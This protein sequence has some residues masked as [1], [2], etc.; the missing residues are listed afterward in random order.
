M[1]DA[2]GLSQSMDVFDASSND[3]LDLDDIDD[4]AA[5]SV[6]N[7]AL[8]RPRL[9]SIPI[10]SLNS[11]LTVCVLCGNGLEHI[12]ELVSCRHLVLLDASQNQV[13]F[14]SC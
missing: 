9:E 12:D 8:R 11:Y 7:L 5:D 13:K 4:Q 10:G 2:E 1:T 14:E 3:G 6:L